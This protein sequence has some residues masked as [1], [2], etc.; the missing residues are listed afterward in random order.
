MLLLTHGRDAKRPSYEN[1]CRNSIVGE[2][3]VRYK[4]LERCKELPTINF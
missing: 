3:L 1:Q 4:L 2:N